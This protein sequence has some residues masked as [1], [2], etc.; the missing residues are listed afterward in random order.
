MIELEKTYLDPKQNKA[1]VYF[2][3]LVKEGVP[4][5][6][7]IRYYRNFN[8]NE[9]K[10]LEKLPNLEFRDV[11]SIVKF[12]FRMNK[13]N[14]NILTRH[15]NPIE[16]LNF[17]NLGQQLPKIKRSFVDRSFT[18]GCILKQVK[19]GYIIELN[20]LI[21]FMPYSLSD[22]NRFSR[23][24]PALNSI[25]LFQLC[26]VSLVITPE[27][28]VFL[29]VIVSRKN[30]DK[31]LKGLLNRHFEKGVFNL[32]YSIPNN[33]KKNGLKMPEFRLLSSLNSDKKETI[34]KMYF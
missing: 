28:D 32:N 3:R 29:N 8:I 30:N 16:E 15:V 7:D 22:G 13:Y 21:C 11:N 4:L 34:K 23:Y 5:E 6:N 2:S 19:G 1:S 27:K 18:T 24:N 31:L 25:Q 9:D 26:G 17:F 33:K 20:G 12:L 10:V 14:T